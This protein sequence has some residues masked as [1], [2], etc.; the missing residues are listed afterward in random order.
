MV[1]VFKYVC[2]CVWCV[3]MY[4]L[5]PIHVYR[6]REESRAS[7]PII[8]YHDPLKQGLSMVECLS[9]LHKAVCSIISST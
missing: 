7:R 6:A 3:H 4:V 5:L 2:D 1:C 9:D 8:F